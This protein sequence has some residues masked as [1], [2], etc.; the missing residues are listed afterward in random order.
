MS[1]FKVNK[2]PLIKVIIL[3]LV[4]GQKGKHLG[5]NKK[6]IKFF[7]ISSLFSVVTGQSEQHQ[8]FR[9]PVRLQGSTL[10]P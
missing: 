5:L 10:M 4:R 2:L 9:K 3:E 7:E 8:L 6:A 1:G